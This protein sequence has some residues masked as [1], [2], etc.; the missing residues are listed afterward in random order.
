MYTF[1]IGLSLHPSQAHFDHLSILF[2]MVTGITKQDLWT[3]CKRIK[4]GLFYSLSSVVSCPNVPK[5]PNKRE[6]RNVREFS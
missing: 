3:F 2:N 5:T 6:L 4:V 1:F